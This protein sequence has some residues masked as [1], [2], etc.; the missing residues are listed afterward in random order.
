[1]RYAR[2]FFIFS[3]YSSSPDIRGE[4]RFLKIGSV[5]TDG[6][7]HTPQITGSFATI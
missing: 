3:L 5:G 2:I 7:A 1:M 6:F 4:E